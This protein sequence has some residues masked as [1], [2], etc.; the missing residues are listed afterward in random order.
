[1]C[2]PRIGHSLQELSV[3]GVVR[4]FTLCAG[5][6]PFAP[7]E[8]LA[9]LLPS[10]LCSRRLQSLGHIS[11]LSCH[12]G[13]N[14]V[15]TCLRSEE[16]G[17]WSQTFLPQLPPCGVIL[18]W[19]SLWVG[20]YHMVLVDENRLLLHCSPTQGGPKIVKKE[21]PPVGR[22]VV[23]LGYSLHMAR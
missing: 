16:A 10:A 17:A 5:F 22:A 9:S 23:E 19:L 12:Q 8:P 21:N 3:F 15:H 20:W 11:T 18:S 1:M 7:P 14:L 4:M 6:L 13:Y 2:G